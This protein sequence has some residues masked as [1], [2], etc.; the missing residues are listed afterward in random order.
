M[1][2]TKPFYP[3]GTGVLSLGV[4]WHEHEADHS[5]PSSVEGKNA[6]SYYTSTPPL[7][8]NDMVHG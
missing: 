4:K 2:P 8:P 5:P 6:W 7:C 1:G 3:V